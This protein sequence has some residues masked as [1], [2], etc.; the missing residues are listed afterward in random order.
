MESG[1]RRAR[2]LLET[3]LNQLDLPVAGAKTHMKK[4]VCD[5]IDDILRSRNHTADVTEPTA[6]LQAVRDALR[7]WLNIRLA[8]TSRPQFPTLIEFVKSKEGEASLVEI[9]DNP[10][11]HKMVRAMTN[12]VEHFAKSGQNEDIA[13]QLIE[14][15]LGT[16]AG[17]EVILEHD[18]PGKDEED[19]EDDDAPAVGIPLRFVPFKDRTGVEVIGSDKVEMLLGPI[20][21]MEE[22]RAFAGETVHGVITTGNLKL[23]QR[24]KVRRNGECVPGRHMT[25]NVERFGGGVMLDS[26][27]NPTAKQFGVTTDE[28]VKQWNLFADVEFKRGL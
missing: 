13:W 27:L 12:A 20:G 22:L 15:L 8:L 9:E 3:V 23:A 28:E 14:G 10:K 18:S 2:N 26:R 16:A 21:S 1:C 19:E 25:F 24:S 11:T 17:M 4:D 5:P 7:R 6:G